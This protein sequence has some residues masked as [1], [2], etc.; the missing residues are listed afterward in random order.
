MARWEGDADKSRLALR[1]DQLLFR[2][3][4]I[5]I[6]HTYFKRLVQSEAGTSLDWIHTLDGPWKHSLETRPEDKAFWESWCN[7]GGRPKAECEQDITLTGHSFGGATVVR[8]RCLHRSQLADRVYEA[9]CSFT[10]STA[11]RGQPVRPHTMHKSHHLGP[12]AGTTPL[13]RPHTSPNRVF[14]RRCPP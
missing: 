2:R 14:R 13:S 5:Y 8:I 6:A 3:L 9:L 11:S 12:M 7:T 4:E 10:A 1:E